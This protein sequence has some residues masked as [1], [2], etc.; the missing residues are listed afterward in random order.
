[1]KNLLI[2]NL[3]F[4][5]FSNQV[6]SQEGVAD[7]SDGINLS[8][9]LNYNFIG[10]NNKLSNL[11]PEIFLG[12]NEYIL[13][14]K[15]DLISS[16]IKVGPFVSSLISIEDST[17]YLPAL[18]LPGNAGLVFNNYWIVKNDNH[19]ILLSPV[20]FGVKMISGFSDTTKMLLQ[21]TLRTALGYQYKDF[22][23]V[24]AVHT[25]GGHDLTSFSERNFQNTFN[26]TESNIRYLTIT[27]QTK[28]SKQSNPILN[29]EN[30]SPLYLFATWRKFLNN[31]DFNNLPNDRILTFGIRKT[32]DFT[33][34]VMLGNNP[35]I[36][37]PDTY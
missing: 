15:D 30:D 36:R 28:I 24:T 13:G 21:H 5:I 7:E 18:M 14:T 35:Q 3:F 2:L 29:T 9:L 20:N 33:S 26:Q 32:I 19:Q 17:S 31:N 4:L 34:S 23:S 37:E 10:D 25:W 22:F 12:W 11:T 1:M 27:I 6:F 8:A 16:Q